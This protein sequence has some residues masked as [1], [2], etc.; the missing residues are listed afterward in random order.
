MSRSRCEACLRLEKLCLCDAVVSVDNVVEVL[1]LQHPLETLQVKNTA[2]LAYL[3]LQN[4]QWLAG[5]SFDEEDLLKRLADKSWVL[6]YPET[7]E[8]QAPLVKVE[9]L[10]EKVE[11]HNLGLVVLD[12]TWRKTRKML[13]LNPFLAKLPRLQ[14]CMAK[15]SEY[16]IRKQKNAQTYSTLEAVQQALSDLENN[17]QKYE[18]M[19]DGLQALISQQKSFS[20]TGAH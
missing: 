8:D 20:Q 16:D 13:F 11:L 1:F 9:Q 14:I 19:T 3:S 10:R 18:K 5:E 2:R 17:S 4:A 15:K 12:G 7:V 6:L